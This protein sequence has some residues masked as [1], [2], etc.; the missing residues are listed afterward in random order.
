MR[1]TFEK[2]F[3][4]SPTSLHP[5]RPPPADVGYQRGVK[6]SGECRGVCHDEAAAGSAVLTVVQKVPV[7]HEHCGTEKLRR[8]VWCGV[9]AIGAAGGSL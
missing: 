6:K 7:D 2:E 8:G 1:E 9:R 4:G 3:W 5:V